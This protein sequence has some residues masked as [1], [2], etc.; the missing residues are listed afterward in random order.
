M[1]GIAGGDRPC[2]HR[3]AARPQQ[4]HRDRGRAVVDRV[5]A[6]QPGAWPDPSP[7]FR[8]VNLGPRT[9]HEYST[10]E[11]GM[12]PFRLAFERLENRPVFADLMGPDI[13]SASTFGR[14]GLRAG[15]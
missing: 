7:F 2:G 9:P 5:L 3:G 11:A 13:G 12:P 15:R 4:D 10:A 14:C 1:L 8:G 6:R